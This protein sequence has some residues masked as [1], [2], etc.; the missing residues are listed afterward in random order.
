MKRVYLDS[1]VLISALRGELGKGLRGLFVEAESF[2]ERVMEKDHTLVLSKLFFKEVGEILFIEKEEVLAYL[3]SLKIKTETLESTK[4]LDYRKY[5]RR[6]MHFPD[7]VHAALAINAKCDCIV[8]FNVKDFTK[9]K[10][11][12]EVLLPREFT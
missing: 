1:N 7:C 6:G 2:F 12:I 10:D 5:L 8:T 4:K 9:V 3:Q 11:E